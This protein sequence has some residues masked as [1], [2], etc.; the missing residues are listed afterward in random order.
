MPRTPDRMPGE[1]LE[2][3]L[4]LQDEGETADNQGEVVFI[5]GS[6]SMRDY[7]GAFN[8]RS[9]SFDIDDALTDDIT[10]TVLVDDVNHNILVNA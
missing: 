5:S 9:G 7:L 6:F 3:K 10:F 4:A 1:S 2:E 8:P